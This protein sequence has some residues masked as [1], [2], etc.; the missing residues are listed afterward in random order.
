MPNKNR[1]NCVLF[2]V[3]SPFSA[4]VKTRLADEIGTDTAVEL[5]KCFVQDLLITL[6]PHYKNLRICFHPPEDY[7]QISKW[8]GNEYTYLPQ[9]GRDLGE[10]MKN[11]FTRAFEN[12]CTHAILLG[13]DSPDLPPDIL[14]Q[15]FQSLHT[16]DCVIGPASDG[17]YYLIGFSQDGFLPEIFEEISWSSDRVLARTIAIF[18]QR[19][20][21]V[22]LLPQWHDIDTLKDLKSLITRNENTPFGESTTFAFI[23]SNNLEDA[24]HERQI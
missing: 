16:H 23:K 15:A 12:N 14:N 3:K 18:K 20:Q 7:E 13:S 11:A 10:R 6:R 19:N 24:F 9:Q 2:F 21:S 8:L 17:G 5:Y 22:H 1:N 4:P